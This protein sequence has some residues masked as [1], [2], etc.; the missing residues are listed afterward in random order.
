[1]ISMA[2]KCHNSISQ[3]N[4]VHQ[5]EE[6]R[7]KTQTVLH[8][9][10]RLLIFFQNQLFRKI[11]SGIASAC[12]TVCVQIRVRRFVGPD[13]GPIWSQTADDTS[14]KS[15]KLSLPRRGDWQRCVKLAGRW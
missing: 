5:E 14:S 2:R 12:Q 8:A 11:L 9:F 13:L 7:T 4:P 15:D 3:N 1:M 10:C 6:I